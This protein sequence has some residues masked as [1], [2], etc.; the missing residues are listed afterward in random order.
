MF[1]VEWGNETKKGSLY[2]TAKNMQQALFK[3]LYDYWIDSGDIASIKQVH[4]E[5]SYSENRLGC[6]L[7]CYVF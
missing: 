7:T 3:A 1:V 5:S 6:I 2:I 4:Q